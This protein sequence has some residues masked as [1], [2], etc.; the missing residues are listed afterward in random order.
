MSAADNRC[1]GHLLHRKAGHGSTRDRACFQH[2]YLPF[3]PRGH[4]GRHHRGFG[5]GCGPPDLRP[6]ALAVPPPA[7]RRVL[8]RLCL[9]CAANHGP[10]G[11]ARHLAGGR[12]PPG[13]ARRLRGRRLPAVPHAVLAGRERWSA[14]RAGLGRRGAC[15]AARHGG[16]PGPGP[17]APL[18]LL[19]VARRGRPDLPLVPVGRAAARDGAPAVLYAPA[20]LWPSLARERA[21]S[22]VARWLVWALVFRLMFLSGLTKLA[23]GDPTWLH[24][25]ALDY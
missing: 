24:F 3:P 5:H 18:A 16:R 11:R 12:V 17:P 25:T 4:N 13:G 1:V 9:A 6:L 15:P 8:R 14:S 10:R 22:A 2:H 21:P 7:R 20:Q 19:P 23:S